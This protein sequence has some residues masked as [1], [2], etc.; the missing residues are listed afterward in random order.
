MNSLR[1]Y[2]VPKYRKI[3][4][5]C[6]VMW[7]D[8][9]LF[10]CERKRADWYLNKLDE[11]T[12]EPIG[13]LINSE[14]YTVRLKFKPHG[15][16]NRGKD[17]GLNEMSNRCVCCGTEEYLTKHHV[18]P[19]CYRKYL[20]LNI[21]SHN[22]HDVLLVCVVCHEKYERVADKLKEE[23]S[24]KYNAPI[25]GESISNKDFGYSKIAST[26][27]GDTSHIPNGTI[28]KL[29]IKLKSKF[30]YSRLTKKRLLQISETKPMRIKR[31]HGEIVMGQITNNQEFMEMW[32]EHFVKN[33]QCNFLPK[34]WSIKTKLF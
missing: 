18:V 3:Y 9:L 28:I 7:N 19:F 12:G 6:Q 10:R 13:E 31:T 23:L 11:K 20:P 25:S 34:E 32:R 33:N 8:I 30:N 16:G 14:P 4:G 2:G 27:L 22:F 29:K 5:N 17:F 26:L 24:I 1:S 21:K 15:L